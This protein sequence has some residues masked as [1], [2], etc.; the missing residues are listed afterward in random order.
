[1]LQLG[2][3]AVLAH[4]LV[5][6]DFGLIA[7]ISVFTGFAVLLTDVG[8][9]AAIVQRPEIDE[10][11]LSAAFWLSLAGGAVTTV[12]MIV[13][14]PVIASFYNEPRLLALG[15]ANSPA[16]LIGSLA[17]VQTALLQREMNFRRLVTIENGA[18]VAGNAVAI[19]MAI[20]G[21]GVWSFVGLALATATF[22][23]GFLWALGGWL[24]KLLPD[25]RS[26]ADIWGFGRHLTG[27]NLVNYWSRNADN[28]LIG[29]F[30]GT[31]NLA[32][33]DRAYN[34]MLAPVDLVGSV[35]SR[36]MFSTFSRLQD[37]LER[38]KQIYLRSLG[39]VGMISFPCAVGLLVTARPLIL[40][41]F[42]HAWIETVPILRILCICSFLQCVVQTNA[43]VVNSQGRADLMFR[44]G[45]VWTAVVVAAFAI[46]LPWGLEGIA[47][48]YACANLLLTIPIFVIS[49]RL[50][51]VSFVEV[52]KRLAGVAAASLLMG[53]A[54]WL[55][56]T[57]L[58]TVV[59][60]PLQLAVGVLV[61]VLT[62]LI[63]LRAISPGAY[64]ELRH[65]GAEYQSR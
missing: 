36:V 15:I 12:V 44:L 58:E 27:F 60:A 4:L 29:R 34:L 9:T 47:V 53:G 40:T 16:F 8:V 37:D 28:L 41:F 64:H 23:T 10:R 49:G 51:G 35:A 55:V 62:Y 14:A 57:Q 61:G 46:G 3:T 42:G 11:H 19:G 38:T 50:I 13:L 2:F 59:G 24:P 63:A 45:V 1:M 33:Y 30:L 31:S 54:V 18:F 5:P 7:M 56:E 26:L 20:G 43:W 17:A 39:L 48:A 32:F 52:A 65:L 6:S 21:L 22:R 25:R